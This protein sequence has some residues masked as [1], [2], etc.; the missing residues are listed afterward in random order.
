[1]S[2]HGCPRTAEGRYTLAR[3]YIQCL[4]HSYCNSDHG[5]LLLV[6]LFR[7]IF[8]KLKYGENGQRGCVHGDGDEKNYSCARHEDVGEWI[9]SY[10]LNLCSRL[11]CVFS[12]TTQEIRARFWY[13]HPNLG[14]TSEILER[15]LVIGEIL[16]WN[17][18]KGEILERN[19][20][21]S[22]ILERNI[23]KGE[24]LERN[25]VRG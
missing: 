11:R 12:F 7:R 15:N 8:K 13:K 1:M 16:E 5:Q 4:L 20:V 10:V 25:L 23:V 24:I 22:E 9:C 17:L 18:V 3:I 21:R 14:T 19:L 2:L 6:V